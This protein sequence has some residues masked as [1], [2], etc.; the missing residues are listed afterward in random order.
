M[1]N[2]VQE[3]WNNILKAISSHYDAMFFDDFK[4]SAKAHSIINNCLYIH[5]ENFDEYNLF[6]N[7]NKEPLI[8]EL[9]KLSTK[10]NDISI[11]N[12]INDIKDEFIAPSNEIDKSLTFD[13]YIEGNFNIKAINLFK[14]ILFED[15]IWFNPIV[16][17]SNTGLGKTHLV[18]AFANEYQ[19][20][21]PN[22]KI[23][24]IESNTF[25]RTIF[26]SI[27]DKEK[28]ESLKTDLTSYDLFI[29]EDIQFLS[30]KEKTNEIFF[31]IFNE[32]I[33]K[34]SLV[35]I[36]SDRYPEELEGFEDRMISRFSSG[37]IIKIDW[38]DNDSLSRI[39]NKKLT[40]SG[41]KLT[42]EAIELISN[43]YYK[44][45]RKLLGVVNNLL[46]N[47]FTKPNDYV[48]GV[49][50]VKEILN[51]NFVGLRN[52]KRELH[53]NPQTIINVVAKLY[54]INAIDI[55]GT[56]RKQEIANARHMVVYI[57]RKKLGLSL[58]EIGALLSNRNHT[59][60]IS[61]LKK[62][63]IALKNNIELVNVVDEI[64]KKL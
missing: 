7:I 48:F 58:Q 60:I 40:E 54:N 36:T 11:I 4:K 39:L 22:K 3:I 61:S 43:Y 17:Y 47:S 55:I 42:K 28:I 6:K 62:F 8:K 23:K 13:N 25:V 20:K 27:Y 56:S 52:N 5:I 14:K 32:L 18:S 57:L 10:Y 53:I 35:I 34:N 26:S 41:I 44:D 15:K 31:G 37:I 30:D 59:T 45:I 50:E 19:T 12:N 63:E 1:N 29:I 16:I 51:I 64:Y 38:P 49:K 33:K 21:Y 46:F 24:Y 9:Q 2:K